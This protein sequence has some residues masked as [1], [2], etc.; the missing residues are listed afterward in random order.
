MD[1]AD[2]RC[3]GIYSHFTTEQLTAKRDSYLAALEARLTGPSAASSNGRSIQYQQDTRQLERQVAA[4]NDELALRSGR[5]SRR[6]IY[7]V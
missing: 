6:P 3:M 5:A 7:L 1:R 2:H 4:I